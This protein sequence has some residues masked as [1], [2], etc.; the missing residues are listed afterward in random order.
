[1][2]SA[3]PT[4]SELRL[5]RL[6][7][8]FYLHWGEMA[9]AWGINRTMGQI[10]AL[11]YISPSPLTADAL[12]QRLQVSRG[13]VSMSLRSLEEWG[14]VQ[15]LTFTGDRRVYY[16]SVGDVWVLFHTVIQ[17]RKRREF[18]PMLHSLREF[19]SDAGDAALLAH[20]R[21]RVGALLTV[22]ETLNGLFERL[23]PRDPHELPRML[24]VQVEGLE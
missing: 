11:L 13:N 22:L 2:Q 10:H 6:E 16:R 19:M 8:R 4:E 9:H 24:E 20:Y 21:D 18:D 5:A 17:E 14:V 12:M 23:L 15:R 7:E 3:P 1:M